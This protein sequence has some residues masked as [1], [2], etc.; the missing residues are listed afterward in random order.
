MLSSNGIGNCG[1]LGNQMFQYASLKGI[2]KKHGY[3]FSI[4]PKKNFGKIDQKV[5]N[6]KCDIYDTFNIERNNIIEVTNNEVI[7]E[8]DYNF[9]EHLFETCPD[10][11]DLEGYFQSYKYFQHIED[12]IREDFSFKDEL[13]KESI[14]FFKSLNS[15]EVISL[16]VRRGDYLNYPEYHPLCSIEY[17]YKSLSNFPL[18]IPVI[19]F[20]DDPNWCYQQNIFSS[21]RF[22]I[23][24]NNSPDFD[25]CL[26]SL[27]NYH[28]ISN[29]S[30]SWWG[31]WLANSQNVVSPKEWFGQKIIN[32]KIE[33]RI[34]NN[35]KVL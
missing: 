25:L 31:A 32:C 16:H 10:N 4:P 17:Y 12:Q 24:E 2:A 15:E 35:W 22:I 11:V 19:I 1:R 29:S 3:N 33:D 30:F 21:D 27:C 8:K 6:E 20:S 23:S 34:L 9:D 14:N 5:L 7:K 18:D 28:I 26:M 13:K